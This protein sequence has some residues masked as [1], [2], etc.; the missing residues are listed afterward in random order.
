MLSAYRL[1]PRARLWVLLALATTAFG[2][3]AAGLAANAPPA[4]GEKAPDFSLKTPEGKD[5]RLSSLVAATPTVLVVLRGFP[6]YQ[7]PFCTRQ[8]GE[9][10]A[11][12]D[13]IRRS[14]GQVLFVYPG[15]G[16]D[17]DKRAREFLGKTALPSNITLAVDPDYTFTRQY[18]LRWDAPRETAYPSTFV[19]DTRG[20]VRFAL[21]SKTHGGR[22]SVDSVLKEL[23]RIKQP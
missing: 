5:V 16:A 6:G 22:S 10:I 2:V 8:A 20:V 18:G 17:L 23:A 19:M 11:R 21:V 1:R 9:F 3:T 13:E 14:G 15:P 4:V 7:C 12:A